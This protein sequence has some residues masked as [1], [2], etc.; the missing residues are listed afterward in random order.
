MT[1]NKYPWIANYDAG[2]NWEMPIEEKPAYAMLDEAAAKFGSRPAF[3]FLDKK[4]TWGEILDLANRF[5]TGLQKL[6]VKKGHKIGLFLPNC[7]YF[8][9]AYYGV[10]KTGAT[11]VNFN[12]LYSEK[13][14][15]HQI[16]DSET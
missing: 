16:S 12:P 7:P 14:I 2:I 3:D 5:A 6:G 1:E 8:L 11:V 9:I 4:Y 10:L 15:A 13:E